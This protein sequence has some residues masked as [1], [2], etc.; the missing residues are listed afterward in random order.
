MCYFSDPSIFLTN[1][2]QVVARKTPAKKAC[3]VGNSS[4]TLHT[5]IFLSKLHKIIHKTGEPLS[6]NKNRRENV[7]FRGLV[8]EF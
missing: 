5:F 1:A 4:K 2:L 3:L 8:P 6:T 7:L